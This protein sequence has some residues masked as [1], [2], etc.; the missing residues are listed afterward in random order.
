MQKTHTGT[1]FRASVLLGVLAG[2]Q[3][4]MDSAAAST[5]STGPGRPASEIQIEHRVTR[6]YQLIYGLEE[7]CQKTFPLNPT[8]VSSAVARFKSKN[9]EFVRVIERS[10]YLEVAKRRTRAMIDDKTENSPKDP[11]GVS[12]KFGLWLLSEFDKPAG[13]REI[14]DFT[15]ELR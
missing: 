7:I 8:D 5:M 2:G 3:M 6:F 15:E 4:G 14:L 13:E 9:P 1:M 12:C 10:R 11:A